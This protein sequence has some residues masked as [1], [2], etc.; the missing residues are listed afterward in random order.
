MVA[1]QFGQTNKKYTMQAVFNALRQFTETKKHDMMHHA[2]TQ[3]MDVA[4]K[5]F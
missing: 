5:D 4:I 3:D 2:V 1:I